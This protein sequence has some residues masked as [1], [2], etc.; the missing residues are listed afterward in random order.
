MQFIGPIVIASSPRLPDC[1]FR[2]KVDYLALWG[3]VTGTIATLHIV[4]QWFVDRAN[5]KL[6][7]GISI[8]HTDR[9]NVVLRVSAV[10]NGRRP[11]RIRRVVALLSKTCP[12]PGLSRE[13][14]AELSKT[15]GAN[16]VSVELQL[17]GGKEEAIELSPDGGNHLWECPLTKDMEFLSHSEGA[18]Q[19]GKGYVMLTSG[20]KI[21]F[22]F[23]L[24]RSDQWPPFNASQ[25]LPTSASA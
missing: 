15:G 8:V 20:K 7:G 24:L 1:Q 18:D 16:L 11:V 21:F 14:S 6:E 25:N 10:N 4:W 13:R 19:Y 5:L 17:F 2:M 22:T 9:L 3:A 23:N 12:P